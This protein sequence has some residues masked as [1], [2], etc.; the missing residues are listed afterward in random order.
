MRV[1]IADDG[2]TIRRLLEV[3]LT[4]WG[5]ETVSAS[6]GNDAWQILQRPDSPRLAILDWLMPGIDGVELCRMARK[7]EHGNLFHIIILTSLDSKGR[8]ITA[9]EAG[10]DDFIS[11]T[12][13][14]DEL[15][16][17]VKVGERVVNLKAELAGRVWELEKAISQIKQLQGILP[18]CMYCHKIRDERQLWQNLENYLRENTDAVLS[19]GLCPECFKKYY[20]DLVEDDPKKLSR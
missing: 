4:Q 13:D 19:H 12:F 6:D 17:R 20:P 2:F 14:M 3:H 15:K 8:L 5:Y 7:L 1:L 10:A 16:A 11:K 18:I 9:L